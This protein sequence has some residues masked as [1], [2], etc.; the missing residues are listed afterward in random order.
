MIVVL[1]TKEDKQNNNLHHLE[2][3]KFH[4]IFVSSLYIHFIISSN[5]H[6]NFNNKFLRNLIR[7]CLKFLILKNIKT[8]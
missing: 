6:L 4:H 8:T 1:L 3:G 2:K 7:R 5:T